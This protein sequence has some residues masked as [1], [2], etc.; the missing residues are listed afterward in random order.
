MARTHANDDKISNFIYIG[1]KSKNNYETV[2]FK[3]PKTDFFKKR[4]VNFINWNLFIYRQ[5]N[6][7]D[8]YVEFIT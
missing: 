8:Y 4:V 1:R 2:F 7:G 5:T 6:S 3:L